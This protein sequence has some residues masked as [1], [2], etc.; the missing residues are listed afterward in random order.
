MKKYVA[1]IDYKAK[2]G[3]FDQVEL[4]AVNLLEAMKK[5]ENLFDV[6]T[7]YMIQLAEK[8]GKAVKRDGATYVR[9]NV[10][11]ENRGHGWNNY[12]N[13]TPIVWIKTIGKGWSDWSFTF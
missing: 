7:V 13:Y 2:F 6:D 10:I 9:Y 8:E 11:L 12:D 3:K 5:A 1:I 4:D